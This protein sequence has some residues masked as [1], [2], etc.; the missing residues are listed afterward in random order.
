MVTSAPLNTKKLPV[1]IRL[2]SQQME[3]LTDVLI[4]NEAV[5]VSRNAD[6]LEKGMDNLFSTLQ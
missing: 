4:L 3:S 1:A 6:V 5:F 2:S